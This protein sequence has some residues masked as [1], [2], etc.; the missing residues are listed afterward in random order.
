MRIEKNLPVDSLPPSSR[1]QLR[2][3]RAKQYA[4]QRVGKA[5]TLEDVA[6]AADLE[7]CYFSEVFHRNEGIPFR[8]WLCRL[9]I[10]RALRMLKEKDYT[11]SEVAY[12][13]GFSSVR[14]FQRAFKRVTHTTPLAAKKKLAASMKRAD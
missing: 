14:S 6:K 1:L 4:E 7:K 3:E 9:R 2:L 5:V 10:V 11:I 12:S 8:E 13:V